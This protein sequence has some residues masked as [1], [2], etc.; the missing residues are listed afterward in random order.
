MRPDPQDKRRRMKDRGLWGTRTVDAC[1]RAL[2]QRLRDREAV[3]DAP[4]RLEF[5][6]G[7]PRRLSFGELD[8]EVARTCA[9]F[10]RHGLRAGDVVCIQVPNCVEQFV[11]YLACGRLGLVATPVPV[12]YREHELSHVLGLTAARAAVTYRAPG[13]FDHVAM[14]RE[15]RSRQAGLATVFALGGDGDGVVGLAEAL[16]AVDASAHPSA[17][18]TPAPVPGADDV[19]TICWTSGTEAQPK[20]VPRT[21]NEWFA[22]G[23]VAIGLSR[24]TQVDRILNP[25]PLVNMAGLATCF[26]TWLLTGCTVVQH[27]PFKLPLFLG[28]LRDERI[29]H[30]VAPPAVLN[31]MLHNAALVEGID[32]GRLRRIGSGASPLSPWMVGEFE[33][34]WGVSILNNYGSNEGGVLAGSELDV[35][36]ATLRASCF[37]RSGIP[38]LTWQSAGLEHVQTRLVDPATEYDIDRPGIPGELRFAGPTVFGGYIGD[39]S[40][41]D[42]AFDAQGF[43]RSGDLFEIAGD[44][45]QYYRYVG[46]LKDIIIRGGMNI[47]AEEIDALLL[48]HPKVADAA[49]VGCPDESLG[50][51]VCAFVVLKPGES[52]A[53]DELAR[54]LTTEKKVAVFKLPERLEIRAEL[55]RNAVGKLLKRELRQ[56]L[57]ASL[58]PAGAPAS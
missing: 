36:D 18:P 38:G 24:V 5:M 31:A 8:D 7:V 28:Q 54:F 25:F 3:V 19:F 22:Q 47:S 4:N 57:Q 32:F 51:R 21:H 52:L 56:A 37:P 2:V 40:L 1:F 41:T 16:A 53:L 20:G 45:N 58:G 23:R 46:R 26:F 55:P 29:D 15:L 6:A 44:R 50:E 17:Q 42:R 11:L 33:Q 13:G 9:V 39:P 49:A 30:T 10:R 43:Y 12:Q 34:R 48:S 14:F 35:P 27:Q